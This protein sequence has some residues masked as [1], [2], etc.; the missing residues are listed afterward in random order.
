MTLG[1]ASFMRELSGRPV[2]DGD[3]TSVL[4]GGVSS[5]PHQRL[6]R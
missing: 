6:P 5:V 3:A 1:R 4:C 2:I